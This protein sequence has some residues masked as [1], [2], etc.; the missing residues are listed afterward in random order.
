[1]SQMLAMAPWQCTK[2]LGSPVEPD[3]KA[4]NSWGRPVHPS[5]FQDKNRRYIGKSQSR[6][7]TISWRG[8]RGTYR[9]VGLDGG[10]WLQPPHRAHELGV[11]GTGQSTTAIFCAAAAAC[12]T[13]THA[14]ARSREHR[15]APHTANALA[16]WRHSAPAPPT[17]KAAPTACALSRKIDY[18]QQLA[19]RGQQPG[20]RPAP[21]HAARRHRRSREAAPPPLA[22]VCWVAVPEAL[23]A[24]RVN[25]HRRSRRGQHRLY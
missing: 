2:P 24:R 7:N 22:R 14:N 6:N 13:H 10:R 5:I 3:V 20:G 23:R 15:H 11:G 9:V 8:E 21:S 4:T 1:V 25:R 18:Q 17:A 19:H 16:H 12:K